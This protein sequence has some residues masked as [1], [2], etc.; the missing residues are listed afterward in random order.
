MPA[1][2]WMLITQST[3]AAVF[4][5][6]AS[7]ILS[8]PLFTHHPQ[9]SALSR[10]HTGGAHRRCREDN[11]WRLAADNGDNTEI[12][13]QYHPIFLPSR[14]AHYL[15]VVCARTRFGVCVLAL[16]RERGER[17]R[18]GE[19]GAGCRVEAEEECKAPSSARN[20]SICADSLR[21]L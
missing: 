13:R 18:E 16:Q 11:S 5:I 20:W 8:S 14:R 6:T 1:L 2:Q 4:K 19:E 15:C 7:L 12:F 3:P 9:P 17:E 10:A 21:C